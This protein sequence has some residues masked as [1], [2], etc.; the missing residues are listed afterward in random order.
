MYTIFGEKSSA[1]FFDRET[2]C[3]VLT[4]VTAAVQITNLSGYR[5]NILRLVF[6][7]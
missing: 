5:I 3:F 2:L 4:I 6:F 7:L 1:C